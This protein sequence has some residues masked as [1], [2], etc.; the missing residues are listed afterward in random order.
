MC[1]QEL[2]QRLCASLSLELFLLCLSLLRCCQL[3]QTATPHRLQNC[4][5]WA[6]P[7]PATPNWAHPPVIA[8]EQAMM[9]WVPAMTLTSTPLQTHSNL[10][11]RSSWL[12]WNNLPRKPQQNFRLLSAILGRELREG[13]PRSQWMLQCLASA[14][15]WCKI[16]SLLLLPGAKMTESLVLV[17]LNK[18]F[19]MDSVATL[20]KI[21]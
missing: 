6:Q 19:G 18:L 12:C 9:K 1:G 11:P 3:G 13:S 17:P 16:A 5:N 8:P 10:P 7:T 15:C 4:H 20:S 2:S 14:N 21:L